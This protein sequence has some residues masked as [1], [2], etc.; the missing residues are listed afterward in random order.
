MIKSIS[1]TEIFNI[2]ISLIN[3]SIIYISYRTLKEMQ[4]QRELQIMP[5]ISSDLIM[6]PSEIKL[7][8]ENLGA[9]IAKNIIIRVE[10][11]DQS[12]LEKCDTIKISK[13][14]LRLP[15]KLFIL[16]ESEKFN[17]SSKNINVLKMNDPF[18]I[19]FNKLKLIID[20]YIEKL[21]CNDIMLESFRL[22]VKI[23]FENM[24]NKSYSSSY[25]YII[26]PKFIAIDAHGSVLEWS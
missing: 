17:Q 15:D 14:C 4:L 13:N 16:N 10:L 1:F 20:T 6:L 12:K 22:N 18:E 8:L 5:V 21:D 9:G 26:T 19:S 24:T 25:N 2:M 23:D 11:K 3:L 7:I